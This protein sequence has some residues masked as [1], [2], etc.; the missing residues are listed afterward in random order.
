VVD[1]L[2]A[3]DKLVGRS[4]ERLF[5]SHHA[6]RLRRIGWKHALEPPNFGSLGIR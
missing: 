1:P 2:L 3:F 6:R 5:R 4:V